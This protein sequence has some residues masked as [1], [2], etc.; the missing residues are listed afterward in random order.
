MMIFIILFFSAFERFYYK[1]FTI[2]GWK[3][4]DTFTDMPRKSTDARTFNKNTQIPR[5]LPRNIREMSE[6]NLTKFDLVI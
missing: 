1:S 2:F 3:L 6:K 4:F 5:T